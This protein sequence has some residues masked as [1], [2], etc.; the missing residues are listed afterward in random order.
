M[1][2]RR[3]SRP[4][5]SLKEQMLAGLCLGGLL[6]VLAQ[7]AEISVMAFLCSLA[8]SFVLSGLWRQWAHLRRPADQRDHREPPAA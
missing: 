4:D 7:V 3:G 1:D 5:S 6:P 2:A 8:L